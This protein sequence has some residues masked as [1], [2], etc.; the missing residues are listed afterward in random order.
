MDEGKM[1]GEFSDLR[2]TS[3]EEISLSLGKELSYTEFS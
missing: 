3:S 1:E 2:E